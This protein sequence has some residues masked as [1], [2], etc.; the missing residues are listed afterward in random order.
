MTNCYQTMTNCWLKDGSL[1]KK[2]KKMK[3][4]MNQKPRIKMSHLRQLKSQRQR[5]HLRQGKNLNCS[6]NY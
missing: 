2:M 5:K 1:T 6:M 3:K 4:L